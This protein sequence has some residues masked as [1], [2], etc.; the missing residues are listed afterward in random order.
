MIKDLMTKV[1]ML[2]VAFFHFHMVV[3]AENDLDKLSDQA[4]I[5]IL[6]CAP[7]DE[8]YSVFGHTAIRVSDPVQQLDMV[9]NYGTF[10]FSTPFFYVKFG[11]GSLDYLLSVSGFKRFMSEYFVDGRSVWE[12]ELQLSLQQKQLLFTALMT[13]AEP[14]NRA[15]QYDFFYDNCATRVGDI[16]LACVSGIT[17]FNDEDDTRQLTFRQAIAPYLKEKPWTKLG[18]D[19]VLGVPA[20][21][22]TDSLS[23]MFLPDHLMAQFVDIQYHNGAKM[24]NLVSD[25]SQ[26]L[27]FNRKKV[28]KTGGLN[29]L[30]LL[31]VAA[32]I[33][34]LLSAAEV[35]VGAVRLKVLDIVLY[36]IMGTAGIIIAYLWF[37][38][39][40]E[41]TSPNWN[42]L[43][44]NPLWFLFVTNVNGWWDRFFYKVQLF[45]LVF[46]IA[47]FWLLPQSFPS[48]FFPIWLILLFRLITPFYFLPRFR[49]SN[50]Q[51]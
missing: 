17:V 10:D 25:T 32:F 20:D 35:L 31:W 45:A 50:I 40:H 48:E 46:I 14:E 21:A 23:V 27:D 11:H 43:W 42:F 38:S 7:G 19:M 39:N 22:K 51:S 30:V 37:I 12:Q 6:T 1:L 3:M 47:F 26:I 34:L 15:Y 5:S 41:V 28:T 4:T 2:T 16:I 24:V 44:A 33:V 49:I 13:N 29:I 8:L 9:F 36:C 18:I